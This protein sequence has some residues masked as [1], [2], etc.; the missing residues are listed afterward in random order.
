MA[1]L[2]RGL[3]AV[4]LALTFAALSAP[5]LAQQPAD[6][7]TA[8]RQYIDQVSFLVRQRLDLRFA[9][10]QDP[11]AVVALR[12]DADGKFQEAILEERSGDPGFDT[13][14]ESAVRRS[15]PVLPPAPIPPGA[16]GPFTLRL[17][18]R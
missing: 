18:F 3:L 15:I 1:N 4:L 11:E 10:M 6:Y 5:T 14:L 7:A 13:A 9:R 12:F 8:R 17:L 16:T 2:R